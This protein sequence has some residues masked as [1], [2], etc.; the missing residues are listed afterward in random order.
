VAI[1]VSTMLQGCDRDEVAGQ[2][3]ALLDEDLSPSMLDKYASP[4]SPGHNISAI[5]LIGL[6]AAT[7]R[8][9]QLDRVGLQ[10]GFR[11]L[12]GD[13]FRVAELGHVTAQ[14]AMLKTRAAE[15][16]GQTRPLGRAR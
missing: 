7:R 16:S 4:A 9:D 2:V 10:A 14:I 12:A 3:S 1:A 8:Y 15:L 13:E 6:T 5:R 11:V